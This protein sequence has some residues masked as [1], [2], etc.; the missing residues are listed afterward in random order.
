MLT[1]ILYLSI[2][3]GNVR[4]HVVVFTKTDIVLIMCVLMPKNI[5]EETP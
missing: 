3:L 1:L 5:V 2:K 4:T